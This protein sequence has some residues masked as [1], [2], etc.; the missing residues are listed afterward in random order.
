[1]LAGALLGF[2]FLTKMLQGLLVVPAFAL[3]YLV[4]APTSLRSRMLHA[5]G[6]ARRR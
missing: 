1:M 4:A 5:A 6:R 3:A 2:A